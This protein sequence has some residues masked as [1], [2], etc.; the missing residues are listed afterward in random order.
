MFSNISRHVK[1]LIHKETKTKHNKKK[2]KQMSI[3]HGDSLKKQTRKQ[4]N[5]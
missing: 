2:I 1:T 3:D 5:F 4:H